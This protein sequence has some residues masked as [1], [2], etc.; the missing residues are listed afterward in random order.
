MEKEKSN[1]VSQGESIDSMLYKCFEYLKDNKIDELNI[2]F[3][4]NSYEIGRLMHDNTNP[5][6]SFDI[7]KNICNKFYSE[8]YIDDPFGVI[9]YLMSGVKVISNSTN[10][11]S[12]KD[13]I[14]SQD[15]DKLNMIIEDVHC[16]TEKI[17]NS[18]SN[19]HIDIY[20][21]LL[22]SLEKI[23]IIDIQNIEDREMF[24]I[25]NFNYLIIGLWAFSYNDESYKKDSES[26]ELLPEFELNRKLR[27]FS[28]Y[29]VTYLKSDKTS[30]NLR[31][32]IENLVEILPIAIEVANKLN[33]SYTS[34]FN[35]FNM[36]L[37]NLETSLNE[38]NSIESNGVRQQNLVPEFIKISKD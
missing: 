16:I 27:V 38:I 11:D 36:S 24:L 32:L 33:Q 2:L 17:H 34:I 8:E 29:V 3:F 21:F 14:K 31:N 18:E 9:E 13:K 35:Q 26:K 4:E 30:I 22:K 20:N 1:E 15:L 19:D 28:E 5:S 25:E 10:L 6:D 7:F 23:G 12:L 37:S